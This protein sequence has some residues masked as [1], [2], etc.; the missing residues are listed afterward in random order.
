MIISVLQSDGARKENE[1]ESSCCACAVQGPEHRAHFCHAIGNCCSKDKIQRQFSIEVHIEKKEIMVVV[2]PS[3][4]LVYLF[5]WMFCLLRD[6]P[7]PPPPPCLPAFLRGLGYLL[8]CNHWPS[9]ER[10][11]NF[12]KKIFQN[13]KLISVLER[14]TSQG[15]ILIY[16]PCQP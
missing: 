15:L 13:N 4:R 11:I 2:S 1:K 9:M 16:Y 12:A 14:T 7:H 8:P 3:H 10:C 6:N 5:L